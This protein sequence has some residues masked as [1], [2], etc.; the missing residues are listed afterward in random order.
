MVRYWVVLVICLGGGAFGQALAQGT[1]YPVKPVTLVTP[2][3]PG[4]GP[5]VLVRALARQMGRASGQP[6]VVDGR[7]GAGTMLAA[8]SVARAPADGYTVLIT[9]PSTF[10][11]NRHLFKKLAYDPDKD[12]V[13]V[14]ALAKGVSI[15]L[16]NADRVPVRTAAEFLALARTRTEPFSIGDATFTTRALAELLQRSGGIK[17][18]RVT[19][20]SSTQ[21]MPDLMGGQLDLLFTD[22]TALRQVKQG[23]VRALGV[24]DTVRSPLAPDLP[25]LAEAGLAGLDFGFM[26]QVAVPAGTPEA[27]IQRLR[28]M[29]IA[30]GGAREVRAA[31]VDAGLQPLFTTPAELKAMIEADSA[32]WG[33]LVREFGLQPE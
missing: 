7:P 5:D 25:T 33:R 27:V 1:G 16:A 19:Y 26:L 23:R 29:L 21:A 14:T 2:F 22:L 17:L 31:Y 13:P 15:L 12:F 28:E 11:S 32:R 4:N 18:T 9:G 20:R 8:Q 6:V 30:A 10:G 3:A 24:A